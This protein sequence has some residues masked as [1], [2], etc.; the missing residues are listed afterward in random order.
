[1][2][3]DRRRGRAC[4]IW[5]AVWSVSWSPSQTRQRRVRLHHGV[6]LR[7]RGV[8]H[9]ELHRR[10]REGRVEVADRGVGLACRCCGFGFDGLGQA[11]AQVEVALLGRRSRPAPDRRRRAPA[12]RS[13]PPRARPAG[14]SAGSSSLGELR[15]CVRAGLRPLLAARS[16]G[17]SP[18]ATP[19]AFSAAAVSIV[20]DAALGDRRHSTM[21]P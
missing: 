9:V 21:K 10:R 11:R 5:L 20:V 3:R 8:G 7:R 4:S 1:M 19:G 2:R 15:R 6:G 13:R 18:A 14:R 16:C 12:R 17:S